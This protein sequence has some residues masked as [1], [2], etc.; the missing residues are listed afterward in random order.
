MMSVS[1]SKHLLTS[2]IPKTLVNQSN[3]HY[4]TSPIPKTLVNQSHSQNTTV[5][6]A[7]CIEVATLA[8]AAVD[9]PEPDGIVR[10]AGYETV[11]RKQCFVLIL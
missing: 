11:L 2:L 8:M 1:F 4:D 9:T 6:F 5:N 3:S 10:G 7:H